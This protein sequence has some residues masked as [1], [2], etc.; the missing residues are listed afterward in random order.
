MNPSPSQ[1]S[2]TPRAVALG[3]L[4]TA[5]V[6]VG[7]QFAELW[8]HGT[9]VSQSTPPI[10]SFF[11]WVVV[12]VLLNT[13]FAA[14]RRAWALH[15]GELLLIYSMLVVSGGVAGIGF[16]HFVPP[17][18][19][20][21]IY[22]GTPDQPWSALLE[23]YIPTS[24]WFAPR[25]EAVVRYLFEGM[26]PT[27]S[28]PWGPWIA[29]LLS[30]TLLG[31]I[32][33]WLS[34]CVSVLLRR[35]WVEHEKLIFPLNY[36]PLAMTDPAEGALPTALHPFFRNKLMWLGFAV[37]TVLHAFNSLHQYWPA[38]P[39]MKIREVPLDAGLAARPW[40]AARPIWLWFYP[41]AVGLSYLLSR[42]ISFGLWVWYFIGKAEAVL[43]AAAGLSGGSQSGWAGFPFLE[44]QCTGALLML[45][46]GSLW[47]ARKHLG[48]LLR[49][50][51]GDSGDGSEEALRP[52]VAVW[53]LLAGLALLAAWWQLAGMSVLATA[54][55]FGLWLLMSLG[56]TRLVCEGGTVWIG[57]P[58]DPRMLLRYTI[59]VPA[60][61]PRDW[62][63]MGYMRLLTMDWRCLL[64][65]N[66][67][68]SL[69]LAETGE[70][71]PRGLVPA[72]MLGAIVSIVVSFITIIAMSYATPGGGI[73]LSTWRYVGVCQEPFQVT[74]QFLT[75]RGG[76]VPLRLAF[77]LVGMGVMAALQ[78]LRGR[79]LWWPLHPLGYPMAATFAMRNM[80]FSVLVAW[81]AKSLVLRYGGVPTYERSRPFFLG[82]ILGDFFNIALWLVVEAFTGVQDHFLYP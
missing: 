28:V 47:S 32:L 64:M 41:M 75:D 51:L 39:E 14:V 77:T 1:P 9:Q 62:T 45:A 63:M 37:P 8:I 17:L 29:P 55:Y 65:P 12:V 49:Q 68:S 53:G 13:V 10:N 78:V 60:L 54:G 80:W 67:M 46:V 11:V 52:A 69:K 31:A 16:T 81:A 40:N 20:A 33:A 74:G 79:F 26:P 35:Q 57:T 30:W 19:G 18:L 36:V 3:L 22:Y 27:W 42:D 82:L 2:L 38:L 5:T 15:Q 56:L 7:T 23:P 76:P 66:A 61:S 34:I 24:P 44:E 25:D 73:G 71:R 4:A 50:A 59:G 70:L 6:A 43:G 48:A 58:M 72:M 21:P